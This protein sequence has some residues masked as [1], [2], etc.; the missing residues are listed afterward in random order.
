MTLVCV[1]IVNTGVPT[2]MGVSWNVK[3]VVN[4]T[5]VKLDRR[6]GRGCII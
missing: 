5:V 1:F 6:K 2:P 4:T 3:H